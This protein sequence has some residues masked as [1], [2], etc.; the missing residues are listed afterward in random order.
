[1]LRPPPLVAPGPAS[2]AKLWRPRFA[3]ESSAIAFPARPARRTPKALATAATRPA[4]LIAALRTEA[5][6][7]RRCTAFRAE[8]WARRPR[9]A[10]VSTFPARSARGTPKT[11]ATAARPATLLAALR[12]E[13][14]GCRR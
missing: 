10:I 8:C 12:E 14:A 3:A 6:R 4:T 7:F 9:T 1:M 2:A 11:L 5:A 13:T